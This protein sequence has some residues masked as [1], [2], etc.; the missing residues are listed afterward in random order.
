MANILT[1]GSHLRQRDMTTYED[2][3]FGDYESA[4][5]FPGCDCGH[6]ATDHVMAWGDWRGSDGCTLCECEVE[7]EHT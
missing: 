2:D 4:Q 5:L 6:D 1:T 7:W 3:G